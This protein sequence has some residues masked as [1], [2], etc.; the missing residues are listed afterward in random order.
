[1]S[2]TSF[3]KNDQLNLHL[4]PGTHRGAD[5]R[6]RTHTHTHTH[7]QQGNKNNRSTL[8]RKHKEGPQYFIGKYKN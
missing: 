7:I 1:M 4:K 6:A 5:A 3:V 8:K 2:K